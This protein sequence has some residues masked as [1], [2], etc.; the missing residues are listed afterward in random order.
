MPGALEV[1]GMFEELSRPAIAS[2]DE[3]EVAI[4]RD[5]EPVDP[6]VTHHFAEGLYAREMFIAKGVMLIGKVH[7]FESMN[8]VSK[9][10][11]RVWTAGS[12]ELV[13]IVE[14]PC[15]FVSPAGSQ[16]VG[17]ALEDTVFTTIHA[18]RET[19]LARLEDELIVPHVNPL[20]SP[21]EA[22]CLGL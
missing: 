3:L 1:L 10:R 20:L 12:E 16:K 7:R 19:D 2:I 17:F 6:P 9:G 21:P 18:T 15:S 8:I 4:R 13:R 5:L 14:A 11:I 22:P